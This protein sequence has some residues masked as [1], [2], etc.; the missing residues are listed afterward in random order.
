MHTLSGSRYIKKL[1]NSVRLE[2]SREADENSFKV[3]PLL[4]VTKKNCNY[5]FG[6]PATMHLIQ[7]A[8]SQLF[9]ISF[10]PPTSLQGKRCDH[11]IDKEVKVEGIIRRITGLI[12]HMQKEGQRKW[13]RG[14]RDSAQ[15]PSVSRALRKTNVFLNTIKHRSSKTKTKGKLSLCCI[16][17]SKNDSDII[18]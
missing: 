3:G 14:N 13:G 17:L 5:N 1:S 10:Y 18:F 7:Q 15:C 2:S 4:M 8:L 9:M 6:A 16:S 12:S 11:S